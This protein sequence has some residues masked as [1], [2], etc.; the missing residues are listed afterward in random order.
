MPIIGIGPITELGLSWRR[1]GGISR[2]SPFPTATLSIIGLPY[3]SALSP[4][5]LGRHHRGGVSLGKAS[6]PSRA[7]LLGF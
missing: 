5:K 1:E 4:L 6:T 2:N 3:P 7:S